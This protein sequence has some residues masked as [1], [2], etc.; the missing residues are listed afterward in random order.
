MKDYS[1]LVGWALSQAFHQVRSDYLTELDAFLRAES[2]DREQ[3]AKAEEA[4]EAYRKYLAGK[5]GYRHFGGQWQ[6]RTM[7]EA[8][9][10]VF[11]K[12]LGTI[13]AL[14]RIAGIRLEDILLKRVFDRIAE[15]ELRRVGASLESR[16]EV[17]ECVRGLGL[18]QPVLDRG[19]A[20][21]LLDR[22]GPP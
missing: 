7:E 8:V 16:S 22:V 15:N 21:P 20:M 13:N 4:A 5:L 19:Q 12:P 14:F 18:M 6:N 2:G 9:K 10:M 3:Y 1:P 11:V 17:V